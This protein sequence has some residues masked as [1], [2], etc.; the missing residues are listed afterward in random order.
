M[1]TLKDP[2]KGEDEENTSEPEQK[3][4]FDFYKRKKRGRPKKQANLATDKVQVVK[5][6]PKKLP[7]YLTTRKASPKAAATDIVPNGE[8]KQDKDKLVTCREPVNSGKGCQ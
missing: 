6:M 4:M 5:K 7:K 1:A 2:K 8:K 3:S